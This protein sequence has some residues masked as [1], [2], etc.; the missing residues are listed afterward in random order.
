MT[1]LERPEAQAILDDARFSVAQL[2]EMAAQLEPFLARY[3]PLFKRSERAQGGSAYETWLYDKAQPL[4]RCERLGRLQAFERRLR[5][6]A[7]QVKH[8]VVLQ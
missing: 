7:I 1:I 4:L 3:L 8:R 2:E 5:L 6:A